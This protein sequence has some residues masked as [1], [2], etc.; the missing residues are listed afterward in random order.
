VSKRRS[1]TRIGRKHPAPHVLQRAAVASGTHPP[2]VVSPPF[3]LGSVICRTSTDHTEQVEVQEW[4]RAYWLPSLIPAYRIADRTPAPRELLEARG[5]PADDWYG[6]PPRHW[7][8][9]ELVPLS[10]E[11]P[12]DDTPLPA[13]GEPSGDGKP[14][15]A[16]SSDSS[17]LLPAE[18]PIG[19]DQGEAP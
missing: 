6:H 18:P 11:R 17:A 4:V 3:L 5:I 7:M 2:P 19:R 9:P 10:G 15:S 1:S 13:G 8:S 14:S 12:R 16:G